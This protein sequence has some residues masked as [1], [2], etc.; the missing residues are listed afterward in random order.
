MPFDWITPI[1]TSTV[2]SGAIGWGVKSRIGFKI[3]SKLENMK[4]ELEMT[5]KEHGYDMGFCRRSAPK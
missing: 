2:V 3:D 5:A 1:A 4:H